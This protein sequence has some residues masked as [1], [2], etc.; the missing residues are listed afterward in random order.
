L[1]CDWCGCPLEPDEVHCPRCGTRTRPLP[2][3]AILAV[4]V[5]LLALAIGLGVYFLAFGPVTKHWTTMV[6]EGRPG[7][8]PF[9]GYLRTSWAGGT[10]G[11][12]L[13][14]SGEPEWFEGCA[15]FTVTFEDQ[16]GVELA[17]LDIPGRRFARTALGEDPAFEADDEMAMPRTTYDRVVRWGLK[18]HCRAYVVPQE[19]DE[20]K[21]SRAG[22]PAR[23]RPT[24]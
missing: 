1:S 20:E 7:T 2:I 15:G 4:S 22:I 16:D 9:A 6:V 5:A 21:P 13:Q 8:P 14:I 18:W 12:N 23:R 10:L 19:G 17:E 24:Q 11:A 3:R